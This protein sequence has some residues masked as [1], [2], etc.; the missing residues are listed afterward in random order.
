YILRPHFQNSAI[1]TQQTSAISGSEHF[2]C[3]H[4]S[5]QQESILFMAGFKPL[6]EAEKVDREQ[7]IHIYQQMQKIRTF[8]EHANQLYLSAKMPGLTHMYSGQEAVAVG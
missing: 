7:W 2:S 5:R 1:A 3:F 4:F 6:S 8:E